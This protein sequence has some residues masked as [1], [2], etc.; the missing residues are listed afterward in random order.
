[1]ESL[2]AIGST[3]CVDATRTASCRRGWYASWSRFPAGHGS[4]A[5]TCARRAVA[6]GLPERA[7]RPREGL[8]VHRDGRLGVLPQPVS[9]N[10]HS[11]VLQTADSEV[12]GR[13]RSCRWTLEP[14]RTRCL[15]DEDLG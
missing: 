12:R 13:R 8:L 2:S 7:E 15:C 14:R 6:A 9:W 1:M 3:P 11:R 10:V 4:L 5:S